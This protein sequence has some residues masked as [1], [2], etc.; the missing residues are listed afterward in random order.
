MELTSLHY[1]RLIMWLAYNKRHILLGKTQL[2]KILFVCY[3]LYLVKHN[4]NAQFIVNKMF[5]DD[6]PKAWP[7]G[8]V[9]PRSYKRY[10]MLKNNLSTEERVELS[11]DKNTLYSIW[12][13]TEKLCKM[14]ARDLTRWSHQEGT[15]W[16]K[17]LFSE[18]GK[19]KWNAVIDDK[20]IYEY[21]NG[22]EWWIGLTD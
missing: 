13:I 9:F 14:S 21:F 19:L 6:T 20:Y 5:R 3:G 18:K 8:P 4:D 16:S 15:P 2:Q 1:A 17:T 10:S 7:F 22:S 11:K 12:N